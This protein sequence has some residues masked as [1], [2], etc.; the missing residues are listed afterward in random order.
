MPLPSGMRN[1]AESGD[2]WTFEP[3]KPGWYYIETT[4]CNLDAPL[5]SG[6]GRKSTWTFQV[7]PGQFDDDGKSVRRVKL[8][9]HAKH[10]DDFGNKQISGIFAAYG[11]PGDATEK[12]FLDGGVI[13]GFIGIRKD[14]PQ[15]NNLNQVKPDDGRY[16]RPAGGGAPSM[17]KG[18][19]DAPDDPWA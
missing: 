12:Q 18:T 13:L 8:F 6:E 4:E 5:K 10:G 3:L 15:S 19:S 17:A 1:V 16:E 7:A 2:T 9:V 11:L 14:D